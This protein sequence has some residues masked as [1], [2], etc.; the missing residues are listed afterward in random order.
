LLIDHDSTHQP[1]SAG[2]VRTRLLLTLTGQAPADVTRPPIAVAFVIDR[3]G[4]MAGEPLAAAT[5]AAAWAV[6]RV[7][8]T[9][10]VSAIAF[11]HEVQVIA[12]PACVTD[13]PAL[14]HRLL[15]L[16]P[17]GSTNLSGGWLRAR[18]HMEQANTLLQHAVGAT[19]RIVLLTDGHA[20]EGITDREQLTALARRAREHGISTTTIGVGAGYD[21]DLLRA[22]A[23]AGGGNAWYV[24]HA[25]QSH[26]VFAEELTNLLSVAAQG[27]SVALTMAPIVHAHVVHS[28]WQASTASD[29]SLVF[30]LGDLYAS[31]PKPLLLELLTDVAAL[32]P[33]VS[34]EIARLTVRADVIDTDGTVEH[35]VLHLPIAASAETQHGLHPVIEQAVLLA[36]AARAREEA[37]MQQRAGEAEQAADTMR[38]ASAM[39]REGLDHLPDALRT[40]V[41]EQA[42]DLS[43]LAEQYAAAEF[44]E[45][46]AKYQM[47][48][49]Y[50]ARR[51]KRR[52][53]ASLSRGEPPE[54]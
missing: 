39:L 53:D 50:N 22:M 26:T 34:T 40:D 13:H 23:D 21:D 4:S 3:S 15:A 14:G 28:N 52:Y 41:Q 32:P 8:P 46:D 33:G 45:Q 30:D 35:R 47:Q 25:D 20:N 38:T 51:G 2:V 36:A 11:D 37:A 18:H 48:R 7:H 27:V 9:D 6:A 44:S 54:R 42:H 1:G 5:A 17:G 12:E 29:G 16:Q 24:E 10:V 31:D 43:V 49:S 19:R